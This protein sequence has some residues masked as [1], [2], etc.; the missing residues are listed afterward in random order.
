MAFANASHFTIGEAQ[1]ISTSSYYELSNDN[2]ALRTLLKASAINATT[3]SAYVSYA[4]TCHP[5]TR[6]TVSNDLMTW[7]R[8]GRPDAMSM[9]WL[10]GPAGGGK[11]CIQRRIVEL[12]KA[13]DMF[14]GCFFFSTRYPDTSTENRFIV[15]LAAQLMQSV[16][17]ITPFLVDAVKKDPTI[18]QKSLEVQMKTLIFSPLEAS[19][20]RRSSSG[21]KAL[22]RSLKSKASS[23]TP[24]IIVIDGLDECVEEREQ[25][26]ILRLVH[27]MATHPH[28]PFRFIIASR[29]EYTIRTMFSSPPLSDLS[30]VIRL[31][32]Y[33]ADRDV[34]LYLQTEFERLR[35]THPAASSIPAGWPFAEDGDMLVSKAS[36]Q[37]V[38]VATVIKHLDN[39]RRNPVVELRHILDLHT[40]VNDV[41]PFSELDALYTKILH[42]PNVDIPLLRG[43]L[44]AILHNKGHEFKRPSAIDSVLGLDPGTCD[45]ALMDLH[46]VV[47][48][49]PTIITSPPTTKNDV[50]ISFH[51]KSLA[52]FLMS[53]G[54]AGDLYQS[55]DET[56]SKL[57]MAYYR[58]ALRSSNDDGTH[59]SSKIDHDF[60]PSLDQAD[61]GV[62][63]AS[64]FHHAILVENWSLFEREF[65]RDTFPKFVEQHFF[66]TVASAQWHDSW[67][68]T[69]FW[70][71]DQCSDL[72]H[73]CLVRTRVQR[74]KTLNPD[75]T[76]ILSL[77][78]LSARQDKDVC[79]PAKG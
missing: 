7:A 69:F 25:A 47:A 77:L 67:S 22:F 36:G 58:L 30:R 78:S 24:R 16:P 61:A 3:E 35:L 49:E 14:A 32:T 34:H 12:C 48:V 57:A 39:P 74:P 18:L 17:Q 19:H 63:P 2:D 6:R 41:N 66:G 10:S 56:H 11:T 72:Y 73:Q 21:L 37:F 68:I 64:A 31:E 71:I 70:G 45:M 38:Y 28:F 79:G 26:H 20:R 62:Y 55:K 15:T 40:D 8:D 23:Q 4:P 60:G 51:H 53:P 44:H 27:E 43:I 9:L 52:D 29:P 50:P 5:S 46:S 76:W 75:L 33:K 54:R 42:P 13:D 59:D 65:V 1:F